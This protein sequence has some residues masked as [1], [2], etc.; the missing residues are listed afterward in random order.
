MSLIELTEISSTWLGWTGLGLAVITVGAFLF[1]WR[2]SFRLVGVTSFTL[3]LAVSCWAFAY[4][5]TPGLKV[6]GAL[7]PPVVFDNGD[8]LVIAQAPQDFP[9]ESIDPTLFQLAGSLKGGGRNGSIVHIRLRQ[10]L[11]AGDGISQP[12]IIGEVTRNIKEKITTSLAP[13]ANEN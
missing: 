5:Y 8:D 9:K 3:L 2:Q 11:P 13:E 7:N 12:V 4:S 6:E 10:V 1:G